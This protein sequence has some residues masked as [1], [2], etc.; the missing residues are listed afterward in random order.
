VVEVPRPVQKP[1]D[2][3]IDS[4]RRPCRTGREF[5]GH[6]RYSYGR[7]VECGTGLLPGT[8]GREE[9][10]GTTQHAARQG[11]SRR[12]GTIAEV[13]AGRLVRGASHSPL[14]RTL[15][16]CGS[17]LRSPSAKTWLS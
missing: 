14:R 5:K 17:T 11:E 6:C 7:A 16:R 8:P 3:C 13:E 4:G 2:H 10:R 9:P 12:N 15:V 1:A